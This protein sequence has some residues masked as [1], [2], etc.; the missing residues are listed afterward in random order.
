VSRKII[1]IAI[2][3]T[4]LTN[5]AAAATYYVDDTNAVDDTGVGSEI[6]SLFN[7]NLW[8]LREAMEVHQ[9]IGR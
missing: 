8:R 7:I 9:V 1:L 2:L 5:L 4:A 3:F 6:G